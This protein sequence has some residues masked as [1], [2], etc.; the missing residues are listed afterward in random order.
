MNSKLLELG[1]CDYFQQEY[2][3]LHCSSWIP[4]RVVRENRGQYIVSSGEGE[5]IAQLS[6][7]YRVRA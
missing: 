7:S 4:V 5:S 1:W 6:G 3:K 2:N